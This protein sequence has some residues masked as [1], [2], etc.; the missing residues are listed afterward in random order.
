MLKVVSAHV[1]VRPSGREFFVE[2]RD[3]LL[4]A[5]LKAG[6]N[7]NYGCGNGTCGLCKARVISGEVTKVAPHDYPLSEAER[8]Q[9][10][11]LLCVHSAASS[12]IV[13]ETLEAQR[14]ARHSRPADRR[15]RAQREAAGCRH[16]AAASANAADH[17]VA[18]PRG[19]E[20]DI[21]RRRRRRPKRRRP[22]PSPAA[23]A[24]SAT[25]IS[26]SAA[27]A[28][29]RSRRCCSTARSKTGSTIN[30]AGPVGDFVFWESER[31]LAFLACDT[32]F[33][34][35]K[36]LIEHAMAVEA[37]ES[38]AFGWLATRADGHYLANQCRAWAEAF[39]QFHYVACTDNDPAHGRGT[40]RRSDGGSARTCRLRCLCRGAR[41]ICRV[42]YGGIAGHRR[43]GRTDLRG[44]RMSVR[45]CMSARCI[46][47]VHSRRAP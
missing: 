11:V 41:A 14:T 22:M 26:T 25:C 16:A 23:L 18:L 10:H 31:R 9:G 43:A 3:T 42:G 19:S 47:H 7:F 28:V 36:S 6:L 45:L 5:G 2:G 39:D 17:P 1:A 21:E 37:A 29:M 34:P 35:I 46:F 12:E 4:Q 15:A 30:L 32:G 40:A 27:T 13:L 33:A 44:G 8:L 24:T 20:R 38:L